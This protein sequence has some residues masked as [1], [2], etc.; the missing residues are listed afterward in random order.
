MKSNASYNPVTLD[1]VCGITPYQNFH[2]WAHVAQHYRQTICWRIRT[3]F[4]HVPVLCKLAQLVVECE[5]ALMARNEMLACGVWRKGD[6]TEAVQG[7]VSYV[8][9]LT[10]LK[11]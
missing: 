4:F 2:E 9:A 8:L 6:G 5:A 10:I 3:H 1:L 7:L 11:S